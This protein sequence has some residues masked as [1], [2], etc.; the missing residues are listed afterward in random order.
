MQMRSAFGFVSPSILAIALSHS[1]FA[2][3]TDQ[4]DPVKGKIFNNF[5][6]QDGSQTLGVVTL[7]YGKN[8]GD[9]KDDDAIS[10]KCAL[11]GRSLSANPGSIAFIH[12]ISCEDTIPTP[13]GPLHSNIF[14]HTLGRFGPPENASQ[15]ATFEETSVLLPE[16]S[17]P[18]P[19]GIFQGAT[20][21]SGIHVKGA[22]YRTGAIDMKFEG[23]ICKPGN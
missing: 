17:G 5:I 11:V 2:F 15:V 20:S 14:L 10:L 22:V 1:A 8:V 12:T 16:P 21:N 23:Q 7:R 6:A 4:C 13:M 19:T 3:A 18:P 9:D